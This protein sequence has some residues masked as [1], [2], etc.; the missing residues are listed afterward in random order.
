[1]GVG[2]MFRMLLLSSIVLLL[3]ACSTH[4]YNSPVSSNMSVNSNYNHIGNST[5]S[6]IKR[7][8]ENTVWRMP[9]EAAS[10]HTQTIYFA[11]N[12]LTDGDTMS[13]QDEKSNTVGS[14]KI[15]MTN[16]YGGSYCRLVNSQVWYETKTRNLS[17]YACSTNGGESWSFRPA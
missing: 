14:V 7:I 10:K 4:T 11:I 3:G 13:W 8:I 15:V 1:M 6:S 16:T 12:N 17:E 2:H 5:G 9:P